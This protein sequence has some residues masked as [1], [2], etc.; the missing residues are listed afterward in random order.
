MSGVRDSWAQRT[1][2]DASKGASDLALPEA[3]D[4]YAT[5][6]PAERLVPLRD[7]ALQTCCDETAAP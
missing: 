5:S 6:L 3:S 1:A 2:V 7:S 4:S